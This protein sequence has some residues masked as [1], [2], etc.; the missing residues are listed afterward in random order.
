MRQLHLCLAFTSWSA[1]QWCLAPW[2]ADGVT[3]RV[4]LD[5]CLLSCRHVGVGYE[6]LALPAGV[7][8]HSGLL[9]RAA[10]NPFQCAELCS[11]ATLA[12]W[13]YP[14]M[15]WRSFMRHRPRFG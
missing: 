5:W 2:C 1:V 10:C 6:H 12:A 14:D 9:A 4:D 8:M 15:H 13:H 3:C 7:F 11:S